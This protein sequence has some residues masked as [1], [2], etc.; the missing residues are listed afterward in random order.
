VVGGWRD[1]DIPAEIGTEELLHA[2]IHVVLDQFCHSV[3]GTDA[4]IEHRW[5][6]IMGFT[7]DS[8]PMVGAVSEQAGLHMAA[9]YSGHGVSMAFRCGGRVALHAIGTRMGLPVAF[10]PGRFAARNAL[11][12]PYGQP[13][14]DCQSTG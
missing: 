3:A 2:A 13:D 10:D 12:Y 11:T 5:A 9:G 7:P 1:H 8:L 6:G 14:V 4:L